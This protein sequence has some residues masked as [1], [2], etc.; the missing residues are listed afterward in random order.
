[1]EEGY[2]PLP[3]KPVI[4]PIDLIVNK[5]IHGVEDDTFNSS[6]FAF[7]MIVEV[8]EYRKKE[9]FCLSCT[10]TSGNN[11]S[12]FGIFWIGSLRSSNSIALM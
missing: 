7:L 12:R 5:R 3:T 9:A 4:E 8:V 6:P 10:C 1:M 11:K 2:T